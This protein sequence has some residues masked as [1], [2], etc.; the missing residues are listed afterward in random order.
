[1]MEVTAAADRII[2]ILT[3]ARRGRN[4]FLVVAAGK[5]W[6]AKPQPRGFVTS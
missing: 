5:G 4:R 2:L 3:G 6:L 1:M